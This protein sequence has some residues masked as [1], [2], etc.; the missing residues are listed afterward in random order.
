M[1]LETCEEVHYPRAHLYHLGLFFSLVQVTIVSGS[2]VYC[3]C[4]IP[5]PILHIYT[6]RF[7]T[8]F[9]Q[10]GFILGHV[11]QKYL[12]SFSCMLVFRTTLF[13]L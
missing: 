11:D 9:P 13:Q 2:S 4:C 1:V 10:G 12:C 8:G 5:P 3:T 6:L 7:Q